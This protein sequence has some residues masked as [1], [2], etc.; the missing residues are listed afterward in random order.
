[1]TGTRFFSRNCIALERLA[2]QWN[3]QFVCATMMDRS[4]AQSFL[5][6]L[7]ARTSSLRFW[8]LTAGSV[9]DI[10]PFPNVLGRLAG[11]LLAVVTQ[12][13]CKRNSVTQFECCQSITKERRGN[14]SAPLRKL[15]QHAA[16]IPLTET[17]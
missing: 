6:L 12:S 13:N 8:V 1:M 11:I 14:D 4:A 10:T 9:M 2:T 16:Q 17:Q 15:T 5:S 3:I 7:I